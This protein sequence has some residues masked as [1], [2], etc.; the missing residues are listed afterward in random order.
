M[1]HFHLIEARQLASELGISPLYIVS[2]TDAFCTLSDVQRRFIYNP[3]NENVIAFTAPVADVMFKG[4]LR[5]EWQGRGCCV[6]FRRSPLEMSK[7]ESLGVLLHEI[8]H[9]VD[10]FD[11]PS[12]DDLD[13]DRA[14]K[15]FW[16]PKTNGNEHHSPRWLQASVHLWWRACSMGYKIPLENVVNLEQYGFNRSHLLPLMSEARQR[17]GESIESILRS[18]EQPTPKR[19][20]NRSTPKRPRSSIVFLHGRL[21]QTTG[22]K[23]MID[24]KAVSETEFQT[25]LKSKRKTRDAKWPV[26]PQLQIQF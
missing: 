15:A 13:T 3:S 12:R 18:C 7:A 20:T 19:A 1:D 9:Y 25:F 14:V 17:E 23:T 16:E 26:V 2:N 6:V 8:G 21:V 22:S 5:Y 4:Y 24:G 11:N 10:S